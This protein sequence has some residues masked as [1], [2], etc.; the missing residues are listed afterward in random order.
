MGV[1]NAVIAVAYVFWFTWQLNTGKASVSFR[2][3]S[4]RQA[5][6]DS[7]PEE[8]RRLEEDRDLQNG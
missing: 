3:G 1:F 6:I 4:A 7:H 2:R 5:Y 8:M